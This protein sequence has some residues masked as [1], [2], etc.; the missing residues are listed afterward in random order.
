MPGLRGTR[1]RPPR[2]RARRLRGRGDDL[3]DA[4]T[5]SRSPPQAA[6][7]LAPILDEDPAEVLKSLTA[8]SGFSY[9]AHKV[10]AADRGA[11]RT[12]RAAGHR[13]APRQPPHLPAGRAGGAGDRRRRLR[14]RG[15]DRA[16]GG[17]GIG[18]AR[19]RRRTAHRQGRARRTD[20]AGNGAAK[21]SD[22][23]RH[24]AHARPGDRGEDRAGAGRS[25]RNLRAEGRDGDRHGPAQLAD[26]GDGQLAAGR[27]RRPL[28]SAS[29]E[30][31]LNRATGFTYEPGSTFKAFTVSAALEE[32]EVT[33]ETTFTLPPQ[34]HVA[35]RDDRRRRGAADRDPDASPKSSPTPPTSAPRR[36]ACRLGA[37]KFSRWINRFGFGRPTG[38]QF[39]GEEQ[40]LVPAARRI[41]GL[42]DGQPADRP[43]ALGDADADGRRLHGDRQRRHPAPPAAD[44]EGRRRTGRTSR[45]GSG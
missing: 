3:R 18:A 25:R 27:P 4:R 36:S 16:R 19:H 42:D 37:E 2:Q 21:P 15:P 20:P 40:G 9:V 14:K 39:P 1:A 35:D 32:K 6:E 24:P 30:D 33:P 34:L 8:E 43:G 29:P 26:P 10:D 11:D 31:L 7:K 28:R 13:R 38:V 22:G 23:E 45:R 12:A 44:R 5:R 17:R 41:L